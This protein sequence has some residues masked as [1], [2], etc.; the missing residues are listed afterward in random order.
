MFFFCS[1][2]LQRRLVTACCGQQEH[3]LAWHIHTEV[4]S[5]EIKGINYRHTNLNITTVVG[6]FKF[7]NK[8][9]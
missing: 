5:M 1:L 6:K 7:I 8:S 2:L 9:F 4:V 3:K